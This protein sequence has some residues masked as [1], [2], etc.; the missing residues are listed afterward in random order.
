M[1][2]I[3]DLMKKY[4]LASL[5]I[6]YGRNGGGQAWHGSLGDKGSIQL[7]PPEPGVFYGVT[8][9]DAVRQVAESIRS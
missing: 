9:D 2:D 1:A 4:G 3:D 8:L 6:A 7:S 5:G